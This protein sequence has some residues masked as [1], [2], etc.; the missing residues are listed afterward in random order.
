MGISMWMHIALFFFSFA[1]VG[2][3]SS[4]LNFLCGA[5]CYSTYLNCRQSQVYFYLFLLFLGVVEGVYNL[6]WEE[7]G[8]V[9]ILGKLI[10]MVVYT[11]ILYLDVKIIQSKP[12]KFDDKERKVIEFEATTDEILAKARAQ[13]QKEEAV[14]ADAALDVP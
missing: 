6:L 5:W 4:L 1:I 3:K 7:N 8:N 13:R 12:E 10:N 11:I 9:Q 14:A 2:F